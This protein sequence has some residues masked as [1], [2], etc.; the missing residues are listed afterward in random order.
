[1]AIFI[2]SQ[3]LPKLIELWNATVHGL[4]NNNQTACAAEE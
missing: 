3:I 4:D 2:D 1:M